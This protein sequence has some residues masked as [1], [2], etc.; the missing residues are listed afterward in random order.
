MGI[1]TNVMEQIETDDL[2]SEQLERFVKFIAEDD[3]DYYER[4]IMHLP[5]DEQ[6]EFFKLN[7]EFM[8]DYPVD[9][10][11]VNIDLLRDKMYRGIL[12]RIRAKQTA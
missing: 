7:P 10:D 8:K 3:M 4:E 9:H 5:V 2:T 1:K 11:N 12:R 6:R